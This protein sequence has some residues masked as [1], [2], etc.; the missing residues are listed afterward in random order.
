MTQ[1]SERPTI[2]VGASRGLGRGVASAF[3][4]SGAAVVAVSRT[5]AGF[6]ASAGITEVQADGGDPAL[7]ARLVDEHEP[8]TVVVVGGAVPHMR[9]LREQTWETFTVNW[10]NDVRMT[11]HW[12]RE[13]LLKPLPP[14]SRVVV[15]SS[16]AAQNP[17]GSPLSGGYAGAKAMQGL[18]T[19]YAQGEADEEGLDI[20]FTTVFSHYAP[21]GGV[22]RAALRAYA[23]QGGITVEE[24]LSNHGPV[25]TPELAGEAIVELVAK[26]PDGVPAYMMNGAGLRPL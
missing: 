18:L 6:P 7:V 20:T 1:R 16:G 13:A 2:V 8:G 23:A 21:S 22:G 24:L 19:R 12:L 14:G 4:G 25:L 26:D 11:L 3:A 5:P 9:P 10:D 15:V 17:G